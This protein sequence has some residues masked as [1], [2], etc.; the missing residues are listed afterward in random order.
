MDATDVYLQ[1]KD[2][3]ESFA[4]KLDE[5]G[6]VI[7]GPRGLDAG[8]GERQQHKLIDKMRSSLRKHHMKLG[9]L[10]RRSWKDFSR[11]PVLS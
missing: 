1:Q 8:T 7:P 4:H 11:Q 5:G 9:I 3:Y 6:A 10:L 2:R